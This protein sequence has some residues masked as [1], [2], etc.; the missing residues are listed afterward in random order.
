MGVSL[1]PERHGFG[2]HEEDVS[3]GALSPERFAI[4]LA[5]GHQPRPTAAT[6][7]LKDLWKNASA[8]SRSVA[9]EMGETLRIVALFV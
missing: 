6:G 5:A 3:L 8:M 4:A 2:D 1:G 9:A 7:R